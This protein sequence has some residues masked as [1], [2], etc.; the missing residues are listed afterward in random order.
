L[1]TGDA[2]ARRTRLARAHALL[3]RLRLR[4]E[5]PMGGTL[6][7]KRVR[8]SEPP[9]GTACRNHLS[10]RRVSEPPVGI[11]YRN[12]MSD[13]RVSDRRVSDASVGMCVG[14]GCRRVC[15]IGG[16]TVCASLCLGSLTVCH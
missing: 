6:L 14:R 7:G 8:V 16:L 1:P 5:E 15:R 12:H 9:V 11:A 13:R 2:E 10:D 4:D 3:P